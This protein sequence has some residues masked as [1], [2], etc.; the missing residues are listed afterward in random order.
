VLGGQ[1]FGEGLQF[2]VELLSVAGERI[3]LAGELLSCFDT[4]FAC[5]L[6][7]LLQGFAALLQGE[8][9]LLT[10]AGTGD[11][12]FEIGQL[13]LQPLRTLGFRL[14]Q[15]LC[16]RRQ[17]EQ[18]RRQSLQL[19]VDFALAL[20]RLAQLRAEGDMAIAQLL[21]TLILF[22]Q[23][24]LRAR[25]LA[26]IVAVE[27]GDQRIGLVPGMLAAAA[28]RAGF[29]RN[30]RRAQRLDILAARQALAFEQGESDLERLLGSIALAADLFAQRHQAVQFGLLATVGVG[31]FAL[32]GDE[33]EL[34]RPELM[35]RLGI[36]FG[37]APIVEPAMQ[38]GQLFG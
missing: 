16:M 29:A 32:A 17:G 37:L 10:L 22:L 36:A 19:R 9:L 18:T 8:Q 34:L 26:V 28:D 4:G 30:Q 1:Q 31:E 20:L 25:G 24:L 2:L 5:R 12:V 13:S 7:G 11:L 3:A 27:T 33:R 6:P 14:L 21:Q 15:Q 38:L 23:R 35:Q